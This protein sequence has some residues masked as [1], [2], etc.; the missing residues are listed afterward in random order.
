MSLTRRDEALGVAIFLGLLTFTVVMNALLGIADA[1]VVIIPID[2]IG[3]FV[4]IVI[5]K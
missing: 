1:W 5:L 4:T 2:L 3:A